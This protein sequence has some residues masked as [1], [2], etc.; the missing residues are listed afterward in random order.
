MIMLKLFLSHLLSGSTTSMTISES[1][2]VARSHEEEECHSEAVLTS[3]NLQQ[4]LFFME[5][6]LMENIFQ[7]KLA[8]YRQFPILLGLFPVCSKFSMLF[9]VKEL[10]P[11]LNIPTGHKSFKNRE[12]R[13]YE[14]SAW[15]LQFSTHFDRHPTVLTGRAEYMSSELAPQTETYSKYQANLLPDS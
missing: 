15:T 10:C 11:S 5:R 14:M 7:P 8:A 3:P 9:K 6:I 1:A 13:V 12:R 2:V 4:D